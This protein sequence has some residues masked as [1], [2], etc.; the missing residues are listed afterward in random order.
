MY[1]MTKD[2]SLDEVTAANTVA[3]A[4]ATTAA[5]RAGIPYFEADGRFVYAIYPDGHRA[6]VERVKHVSPRTDEPAA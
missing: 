5:R 2:R 1:L 4:N 3:I 6:V